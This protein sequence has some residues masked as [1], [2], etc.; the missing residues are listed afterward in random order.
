MDLLKNYQ[1]TSIKAGW[2]RV[3]MLL[4]L[5]DRAINAVESCEIAFEAD[6]KPALV[7]HELNLRKTVMT[8]H[9]GLKPDEDEVAF[10]IARLLHFAMVQYDQRDFATCKKVFSE[11]RNGFAQIAD[12]ANELERQGNI[13]SL[14]ETDAFE[15]IA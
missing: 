15:S 2:T 1:R 7:K 14:P 6:E 5:Y 11:I 9:A 13:P 12:E 3:D 4:M 8:I 10:N